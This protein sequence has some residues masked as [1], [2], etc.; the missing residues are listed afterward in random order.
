MTGRPVRAARCVILG[1]AI[2]LALTN[3]TFAASDATDSKPPLEVQ[4]SDVT[5]DMATAKRAPLV[6]LL[7]NPSRRRITRAKL[8]FVAPAGLDAKVAAAPRL[9]SSD[10]LT[11][12]V[13]VGGDGLAPSPAKLVVLA[14]YATDTASASVAASTVTVTL[15]PPVAATS[16][17]KAEVLPPEGIVDERNPLVLRLRIENP[18]RR[19]VEIERVELVAPAYVQIASQ[20]APRK[21]L[22]AG[23]SDSIPVTLTAKTAIPGTYT[24]VIAFKARFRGAASG[25]EPAIAQGKVTVGIPGVSEALQF[26]GIPSL[27]LLPGILAIITFT[28]I[29]ALLTHRAAIDWKQPALLVIAVILSFAAA[30]IYPI[31]TRYGFGIARDYLHGYDLSDVIYLWIGSIL[32]GLIAAGVAA[33][34]VW[35]VATERAK[36]ERDRLAKLGLMEPD[37]ADEAIDVLH[38][39]ER[40][41]VVRLRLTQMRRRTDDQHGPVLLALPFGAH[42]P[43]ERWLVPRAFFS[44]TGETP[45]STA[46]VTQVRAALE[47]LER[48]DVGAVAALVAAVDQGLAAGEIALRWG[49]NNV[50]GPRKVNDADYIAPPELGPIGFLGEQP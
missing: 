29:F 17:L 38:K 13:N 10:D 4:P 23:A 47:S 36:R 7:H 40:Q 16:A 37:I 44:R 5:F 34:T 49:N 25:W 14:T 9:P 11:W 35:L 22:A 12:R 32:A 48:D 2:V 42:A 24:L 45:E 50:N 30:S 1:A 27:L 21:I 28:T 46:R 20:P 41:A 31:V 8:T 15:Q 39:L 26:L 43:G 6:V 18:T 3:E 33:S 19:A